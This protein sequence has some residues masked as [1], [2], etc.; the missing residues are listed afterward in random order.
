[1][2]QK[3]KKLLMAVLW[4]LADVQENPSAE[5]A[6]YDMRPSKTRLLDDLETELNKG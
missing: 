6:E 4:R 3:E 5:E 2:R 1:M